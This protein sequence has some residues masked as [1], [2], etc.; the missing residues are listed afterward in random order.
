MLETAIYKMSETVV[1][2]LQARKPNEIPLTTEERQ[3]IQAAAELL[4]LVLR[5]DKQ[6]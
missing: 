1:S 3:V 6:K 4:L 2:W 5:M